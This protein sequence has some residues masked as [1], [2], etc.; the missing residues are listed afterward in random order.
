MVTLATSP[1]L[2][3]GFPFS[4]TPIPTLIPDP[5]PFLFTPR[6]RQPTADSPL[7]QTKLL[8]LGGVGHKSEDHV[9]KGKGWGCQHHGWLTDRDTPDPWQ[10]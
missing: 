9:A 1:M 8:F 2:S 5:H 4:P 3:P 6:Q 7:A 10:H